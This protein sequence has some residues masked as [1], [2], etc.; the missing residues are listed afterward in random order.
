MPLHFAFGQRTHAVHKVVPLR[1][2]DSELLLYCLRVEACVVRHLDRAAGAVQG[3]GQG[4]VANHTYGSGC[5]RGGQGAVAGR[6]Q[7]QVTVDLIVTLERSTLTGTRQCPELAT[8]FEYPR[9]LQLVA[10]DL[11]EVTIKLQNFP[12]LH[13]MVALGNHRQRCFGVR[14]EEYL[15]LGEGMD[16]AQVA[17]GL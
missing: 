13:G 6:G 12:R 5:C 8:T 4:V 7:Q 10:G 9:S 16:R 11:G 17:D 3:D 15:L 14:T 1:D 2:G